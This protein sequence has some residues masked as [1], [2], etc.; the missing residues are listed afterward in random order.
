MCD[1]AVGFSG[2]QVLSCGSL[3]Y[4]TSAATNW[5]HDINGG[6]DSCETQLGA[7]SLVF[8]THAMV[9]RTELL[10]YMDMD[11][12]GEPNAC[13]TRSAVIVSLFVHTG[14]LMTRRDRRCGCR[15]SR[16]ASPWRA[17]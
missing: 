14:D 6:Q 12:R 9:Q 17:P 5:S 15:S 8:C 3:Q 13:P 4:F 1:T 7:Y 16:A 11:F 10:P 2:D